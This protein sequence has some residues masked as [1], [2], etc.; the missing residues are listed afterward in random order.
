MPLTIVIKVMQAI[1]FIEHTR[2]NCQAL[3]GMLD[4]KGCKKSLCSVITQIQLNEI[5]VRRDSIEHHF[6]RAMPSIL[7]KQENYTT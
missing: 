1:P 7:R 2:V 4:E 5:E 3:H 6:W